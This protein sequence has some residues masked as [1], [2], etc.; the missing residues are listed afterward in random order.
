MKKSIIT[1]IIS[2]ILVVVISLYVPISAECK[3]KYL[4]NEKCR[5][6]EYWECTYTGKAVKPKIKVYDF[7]QNDKLLKNGRDYQVTYKNNVKVGEGTATINF[8]GEYNGLKALKPHISIVPRCTKIVKKNYSKSKLK[9][10]LSLKKYKE[11]TQTTINAYCTSDYSI[12]LKDFKSKGTNLKYTIK[13]L[14][15]GY[16]YNICIV[17]ETKVKKQWYCSK[18]K[19]ISFKVDEKTRKIIYF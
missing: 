17:A 11:T 1:V 9:L 12:H 6:E 19:N 18:H 5:V 13:D 10:T 7:P 2:V 3:T 14:T 4:S 8:I 15:P 16:S